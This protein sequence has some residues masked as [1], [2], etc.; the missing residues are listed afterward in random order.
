MPAYCIKYFDEDDTTT[1]QTKETVFMLNLTSAKKSAT[2]LCYGNTS[3]IEI[4]DL[5]DRLLA[6]RV[7][8][9]WQKIE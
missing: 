1:P 8:G 5:M 3:I 2:M 9:K 4:Y 7:E 6:K